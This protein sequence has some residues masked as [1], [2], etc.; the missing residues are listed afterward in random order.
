M[1]VAGSSNT[2]PGPSTTTQSMQN[3][4]A[5]LDQLIQFLISEQETSQI[6]Q[7]LK[8]FM[9]DVREPILA[10]LLPTGQDPL[11]LLDPAT[12]TLGFLYILS[13]RLTVPGAPPSQQSTVESFCRVFNPE[14]ARLAPD[15]VTTLAKAIVRASGDNLKYALGPLRDL[16]TRYPPNSSYLTTLHPIYLNACITTRHYTAALP[17]LSAHILNVDT[18]L[19]DLHYNDNLVYHYAGGVALGALKRWREAEEFFEIVVTAPAQVPAAIQLEALKKL[20]LLQL[21][22]YGKASPPPKYTHSILIRQLKN[23]PY[24]AFAKAYP[25]TINNLSNFVLKDEELYRT[26]KN[27]G[28][29][30]QAIARAPRWLIKKL[31]LTYLTLGLGDIASQIG[32]ASEEEVRALILDM[33]QSD[34]INASISVD[35]TVTFA[36]SV[37]QFSKAEVDSALAQ[38]QA[39]SQLLLQLERDMNLSKEYIAKALKHKDEAWGAPDEDMYNIP[40]SG[41][42]GDDF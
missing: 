23:S 17:I 11:D 36:E 9:K 8:N 19:S 40:S 18:A 14:Q 7:T 10:S 28:L 2:Q 37:A 32:V 13:A 5:S 30:Q 31:T 3:A 20:A 26:D 16:T 29:I 33:A 35:G 38:A 27:F 41:G 4:P 12:H 24:F 25:L 34:E 39:Q 21:I 6:Q 42:W 22:L 15:R 1:A